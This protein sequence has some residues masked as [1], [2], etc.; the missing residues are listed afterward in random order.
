MSSWGSH[1]SVDPIAHR[2]VLRERRRPTV[3]AI[4]LGRRGRR[5]EGLP[6]FGDVDAQRQLVT[7]DDAAR[8]MDDVD[9]AAPVRFGVE[10]TLHDEGSIV[11][12]L[13]EAR[14]TLTDTEAQ[15]QVGAPAR[16]MIGNGRQVRRQACRS[17]RRSGS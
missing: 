14:A 7:A 13:D 1:S 3:V 15:A 5:Q 10:R 4:E 2:E 6:A 16:G 9:V 17:S 8:R 11:D 12:A